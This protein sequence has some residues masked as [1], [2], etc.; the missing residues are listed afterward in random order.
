MNACLNFDSSFRFRGLF[1]QNSMTINEIAR[2]LLSFSARPQ[3]LPIVMFFPRQE[4]CCQGNN[5]LPPH[6]RNSKSHLKSSGVEW[7]LRN[8]PF[9]SISAFSHQGRKGAR[10]ER[11]IKRGRCNL[12]TRRSSSPQ[13]GTFAIW[14]ILGEEKYS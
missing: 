9:R 1:S 3:E 8:R 14:R 5:S 12:T 10:R 13:H 6:A 11:M 4:M 7:R 2:V